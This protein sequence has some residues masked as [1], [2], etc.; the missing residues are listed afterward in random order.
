MQ[1]YILFDV[2]AF[3]ACSAC[4]K[5]RNYHVFGMAAESQFAGLIASVGAG[6]QTHTL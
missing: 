5:S 2:F 6:D 4:E 3:M 1:E